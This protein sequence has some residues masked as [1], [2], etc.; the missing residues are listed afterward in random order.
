MVANQEQ[1]FKMNKEKWTEIFREAGFNDEDM[2]NWHKAF[3]K[4]YPEKHQAFL[5]HIQVDKQ[6]IKKIREWSR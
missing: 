6:E 4:L 5:E 3:E 2:H 1:E